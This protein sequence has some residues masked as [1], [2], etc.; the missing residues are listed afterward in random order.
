VLLN[1][2]VFLIRA[3]NDTQ[4][5]I[6]KQLFKFS[7]ILL[8][9]LAS[10]RHTTVNTCYKIG[11]IEH[12]VRAESE[13]LTYLGYDIK[14]ACVLFLGARGGAVG[15]GTALQVGRSRVRFPIVLLEFFNDIILPAALWPWGWLSL[16]QKW[17]PGL[18][19]GRK[20]G[21]CGGLT[22]LPPSCPD[23]LENWEPQ[24]PGTLRACPGL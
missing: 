22:T 7:L 14:W 10:V 15:W 21:W 6:F 3:T 12:T 4:L 8:N 16:E 23:C 5:H 20:G 13:R 2:Q 11:K 1:T 24:T 17:I 9:T 18:F 19:P